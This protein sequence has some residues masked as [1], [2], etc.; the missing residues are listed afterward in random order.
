M[1]VE[2]TI[3]RLRDR[4]EHPGTPKNEAETCRKMASKLAAHVATDGDRKAK[5][6]EPWDDGR[7]SR[8]RSR[9]TSQAARHY[10]DFDRERWV[11]TYDQTVKAQRTARIDFHPY[12]AY[13]QTRETYEADRATDIR[14]EDDA[15]S[16]VI[17]LHRLTDLELA[18]ELSRLAHTMLEIQSKLTDMPLFKKRDAGRLEANLKRQYQA[19]RLRF[20]VLDGEVERRQTLPGSLSEG[21]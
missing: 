4:A 8:A 15:A 5:P 7:I 16:A 13:E 18:G 20:R 2:E 9:A 6:S 19:A 17:R 21:E 12:L 10:V 14:R 1:K 11:V 3:R